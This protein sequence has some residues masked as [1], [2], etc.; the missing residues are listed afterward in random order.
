MKRIFFVAFV[1]VVLLL[2]GCQYFEKSSQTG[3]VIDDSDFLFLNESNES[4]PVNETPVVEN[5]SVPSEEPE[6]V[7][8][9]DVA[10]TITVTE[11][12][13]VKL[14]LKAVDPDGDPITYTFT[15]PLNA[16]GRWQTK[17]GDEGRY[18]V[19]VTA[20]DGKLSTSEDVLIIVKRANR[21][22]VIECPDT[23]TVK[24]GE[25]VNLDCNIYDE[26]GDNIIVSY[27]GWM[28]SSTKKTTFD[29]AGEYTVIVRA[30]DGHG[31]TTKEVKVVVED[32]NRPPVIEP[33]ENITVMETNFVSVSPKVSDPDGD[34]VVVSF[35]KPLDE[36]GE[37]QTEDGDA[38][39]YEVTV[40]AS[41][42]QAVSKQKFTITVTQINTAPVLKPID[43]ITVEEG[44]LI[45]IPVN[46]YDPEGDKITVTFSGFMD[47]QEYR[48][49]YDDAGVYQ[50]TVTVSDG[51]LSTSQTF[52]I[53][54]LDKNR[55]PV[56]V[57]GD[58]E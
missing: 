49:T 22:P 35:S 8:E 18:L 13:L 12:D 10:Y 32:V 1:F 21:P 28:T 15:E 3:K 47:S 7:S 23:V 48:T 39:T 43:D 19:T 9:K 6:M 30:S 51:V 45:R 44:D 56:F 16:Q 4:V 34:D 53:T 5:V 41:D 38:G 55:P 58:E 40:T 36:N 46:A 50:E 2:T 57:L 42:G 33:I 31:Q 26:E 52:T 27:G 11:G 20:S 54:V 14:D 25:T 37:W 29:D 24:E 17:I